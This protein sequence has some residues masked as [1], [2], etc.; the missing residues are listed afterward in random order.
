MKHPFFAHG[1]IWPLSIPVSLSWMEIGAILSI[2]QEFHIKTFVE[3]G[4]E[5]GGL[6]SLLLMRGGVDEDFS[7]F[8]MELEPAKVHPSAAVIMSEFGA[9]D[10]LFWG[11]VFS[12]YG[13]T[14][15]WHIART[16]NPP[17]LFFCD[18]GNK[19]REVKMISEMLT[20]SSNALILVH[21]FGKEF[22]KRDIPSSLKFLPRD[23]LKGTRLL[24]LQKA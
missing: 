2:I 18:N 9:P 20:A 21:D 4:I 12:E 19:P 6:A 11:D 22:H 7:Y 14:F 8:G 5:R 24:L 10:T 13:R 23:Y 15:L 3:I 1:C 17:F 16:K